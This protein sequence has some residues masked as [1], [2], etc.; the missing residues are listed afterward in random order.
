MANSIDV[1]RKFVWAVV[2]S[3]ISIF[4]F[5][6]P[7]NATDQSVKS[8]TEIVATGRKPKRSFLPFFFRQS[9]RRIQPDDFKHVLSCHSRLFS[10][11][12]QAISKLFQSLDQ[13][14][15]LYALLILPDRKADPGFTS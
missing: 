5:C 8:K 12:H 2:A 14:N 9:K 6:V 7:V 3:I 15:S 13:R 11:K 1:R 10:L 4:T